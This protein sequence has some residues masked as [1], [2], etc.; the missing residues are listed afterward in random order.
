[1]VTDVTTSCVM[2][3]QEINGLLTLIQKDNLLKVGIEDCQNAMGNFIQVTR[4]AIASR[5][6]CI[7]KKNRYKFLEIQT[8]IP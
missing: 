4:L 8:L 5:K 6:E 3:R 7:L 2:T 1:M